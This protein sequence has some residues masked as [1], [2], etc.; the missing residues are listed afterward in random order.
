MVIKQESENAT[1]HCKPGA[2][3]KGK[4]KEKR[5]EL[6]GKEEQISAMAI[7]TN[8][9]KNVTTTHPH[10]KLAGPAYFKLG[11]YRGVP[12]KTAMLEKVIPSVFKKVWKKK[13]TKTTIILSIL[14]VI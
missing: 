14:L 2:K 7:P 8:Q 6:T 5:R 12:V 1:K 13:T 3:R 4:G 9:V 11:P 10:S